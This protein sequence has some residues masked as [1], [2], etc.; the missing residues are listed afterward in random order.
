[1]NQYVANEIISGSQPSSSI[2]N[3]G[4]RVNR[5]YIVTDYKGYTACVFCADDDTDTALKFCNRITAKLSQPRG[6]MPT[7]VYSLSNVIIGTVVERIW[8]TG[9]RTPTGGKYASDRM[10]IQDTNGHAWYANASKDDN[11]IIMRRAEK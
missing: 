4:H 10:T 8:N 11:P 6:G 3:C 9:A 7:R 2:A 5:R 1:M